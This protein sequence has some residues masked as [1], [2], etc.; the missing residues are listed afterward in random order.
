[1]TLL[2]SARK[3]VKGPAV[4]LPIV[5]D[6]VM[7]QVQVGVCCNGLRGMFEVQ[8][9]LVVMNGKEVSP[10]E[11]ERLAGK[12][13]SKKWKSSIRVDK[14]QTPAPCSLPWRQCTSLRNKM[15]NA[16]LPQC[17]H[18]TTFIPS[19]GIQAALA[20]GNCSN[21]HSSTSLDQVK[22]NEPSNGIFP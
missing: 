20:W 13:A 18:R 3:A 12:A 1:M 2:V 6:I 21:A 8:R 22:T 9:M 5:G 11:F 15:T 14:V 16:S 17:L 7:C 10:T 19:N 4:D